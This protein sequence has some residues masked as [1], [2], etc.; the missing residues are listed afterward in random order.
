MS[1]EIPT[2]PDTTGSIEFLAEVS[3]LAGRLHGHNRELFELHY[4][5]L[6]F[7]SWTLIAGTR[8]SR[9]RLAWDGREGELSAETALFANSRTTP[10]WSLISQQR[11]G[12]TSFGALLATAEQIIL[13]ES[14]SPAA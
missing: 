2:S 11:V 7:G 5:G 13:V 12:A 4:F 1:A 6:S 10:S 8:K 9:V 3:A 14:G